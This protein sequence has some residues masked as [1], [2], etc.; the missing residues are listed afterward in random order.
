MDKAKLEDLRKRVE[1]AVGAQTDSDK[2]REA[3][4]TNPT[5]TQRAESIARLVAPVAFR[6]AE[7]FVEYAD[8]KGYDAWKRFDFFLYTEEAK[9]IAEAY[10]TAAAIM[11]L[12]PVAD[13]SASVG[14]GVPAYDD[15]PPQGT[16]ADALHRL[17]WEASNAGKRDH[18]PDHE[19]SEG[20]AFDRAMDQAAEALATLSPAPQTGA[21]PIKMI[22]FCPACGVQHI[23]EPEEPLSQHGGFLPPEPGDD[24]WDNPP[25]RSH[26]CHGCG[27]IWRPADVPTEGVA[28]IQ[29]KGKADSP[30]ASPALSASPPLEVVEALR[31]V[32]DWIRYV[33]PMPTE[34]ATAMLGK[35]QSALSA[36]QPDR[37]GLPGSAPNADAATP[38][39]AATEQVKP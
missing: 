16:V 4:L 37:F 12:H 17:Y 18:D 9:R 22:L 29:T 34:G 2:S 32:R 1:E 35:V 7:A 27:H 30:P 5:I 39:S 6:L 24:Y 38:K 19:E 33:L 10:E 31:E 15:P 23:D 13:A 28:A 20:T 3:P 14:E 25:H 21:E 11:A 26:L 8:A 36:L